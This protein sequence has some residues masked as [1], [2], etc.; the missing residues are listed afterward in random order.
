MR[1]SQTRLAQ[2]G[3]A[4]Y[5][6][7]HMGS[8]GHFAVVHHYD[9]DHLEITAHSFD[10]PSAVLSRVVISGESRRIEGPLASW[11]NVPRFY[12]AHLV[13]PGSSDFAL[14]CIGSGEPTLQTFEWFD[15]SYDKLYQGIIDVTEIPSSGQ[16]LVSVQ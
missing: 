9:S 11:S 1:N 15:D 5:L 14:V 3:D 4:R 8:A 7:L 16:L 13:R 6:S 2:L 10:E 12:V